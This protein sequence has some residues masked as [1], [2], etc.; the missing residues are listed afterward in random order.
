VVS[1]HAAA[2]GHVIDVPLIKGEN[3]AGL[4]AKTPVNKAEFGLGQH[5]AG[6]REM[7]ARPTLVAVALPGAQLS[8]HIPFAEMNDEKSSKLTGKNP[9]GVFLS[10]YSRSLRFATSHTLHVALPPMLFEKQVKLHAQQ[11]G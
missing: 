10:S 11:G 2:G 1:A 5:R 8:D 4:G 9:Q 3:A 6:Y 7:A